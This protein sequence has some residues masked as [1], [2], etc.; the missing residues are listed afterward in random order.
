MRY[1]ER[2]KRAKSPGMSGEVRATKKQWSVYRCGFAPLYDAYLLP[3]LDWLR[4][5]GTNGPEVPLDATK[6]S[7]RS[8]VYRS[9]SSKSLG[10]AIPSTRSICLPE[11][12]P[13]RVTSVCLC[14][15]SKEL[16]VRNAA[17]V[18]NYRAVDEVVEEPGQPSSIPVIISM[19]QNQTT[20]WD[21][22]EA[23]S[24]MGRTDGDEPH[25]GGKGTWKQV[26]HV[27]NIERTGTIYLAC[28]LRANFMYIWNVTLPCT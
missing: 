2:K 10:M 26:K 20:L 21:S 22:W 16:S 14:H 18:P 28:F 25:T 23:K 17:R 3:L 4:E 15:C 1:R 19:A 11:D 5:L 6:K 13:S 24:L 12:S 7:E 8:A 9:L 27:R